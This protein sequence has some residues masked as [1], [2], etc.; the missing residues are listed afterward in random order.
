MRVGGAENGD[1]KVHE[2]GG[3]PGLGM[4]IG[5]AELA[6]ELCD[7]TFAVLTTAP[8]PVITAHP[9]S[10]AL[11]KATDE[12]ILMSDSWAATVNSE[13]ADTPRW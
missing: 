4:F 7:G 13:N 11:S 1:E 2:Q 12:S 6:G 3:D 5:L 10:A 9:N 8:T